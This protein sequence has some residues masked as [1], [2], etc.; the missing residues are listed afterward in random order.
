MIRTL[1]STL[2]R[3]VRSPAPRHRRRDSWM[4]ER[5]EDRL[6]LTTYTPAQIAKAY[7]I[8]QV[9]FG[10]VKGDG[11]GQTIAIV[12]AY[13]TPNIAA[14]LAQFNSRYGLPNTDGTGGQLLTVAN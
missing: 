13:D 9:Y 7:G 11:T 12:G 5:L 10:N 8:D 3:A 14:D 6:L 4:I 2:V 1:W